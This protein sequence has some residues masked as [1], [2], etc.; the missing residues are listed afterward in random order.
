MSVSLQQ[1][2]GPAENRIAR[3]L[4]LLGMTLAC[5]TPAAGLLA[6]RVLLAADLSE[7][8]SMFKAGKYLECSDAAQLAIDDGQ[9]SETWR[10][11]KIRADLMTGRHEDALVTLEASLQR[12][13]TSVRLRWIGSRVLRHNGQS[14]RAQELLDEIDVLTDGNSWRY[15]DPASRIALGR[16]YLSRGADPKKIIDGV[17]TAVKK[18]V[19]SYTDAYIASGQLALDKNDFQLAAEE[20]VQDVDQGREIG[21]ASCRERV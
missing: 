1:G 18:R 21:R 14:D 11:L 8:T 19:P 20:F 6:P 7:T 17:Y 3:S 13:K 12:Y 16:Y 2:G 15:S 4:L 5:G 9:Y 10:L